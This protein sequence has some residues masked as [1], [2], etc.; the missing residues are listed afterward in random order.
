[1]RPAFYFFVLFSLLSLYSCTKK[2]DITGVS[3]VDDWHRHIDTTADIVILVPDIQIYTYVSSNNRYL[4]TMITSLLKLKSNGYNIKAVLQTG[5]I[6]NRHSTG[7]W[8][9][10]KGIFSKLDNKIPYIMCTGNHDYESSTRNT[11]YSRYFN[12]SSYPYYVTSFKNSAF[13]NSLFSLKINGQP[14]L[15]YSL[16]FAPTD[17]VLTWADSIAAANTDKTGIVLTHAYLYQNKERFNFSAYGYSQLN[18][19]YG[20]SLPDSEQINDGEEIWQKLVYPNDAIRFV[21]CGHMDYPNYAGNLISKNIKGNKCLQ[22]LFDTQ[23]FPEG[24]EGLVQVLAFNK[25]LKTVD[26]FT[27]SLTEGIWMSGGSLH[28]RYVR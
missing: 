9:T 8:E 28:Y 13:E 4:D 21:L 18:S 24:G 2:D 1:M 26:I 23:S 5:D 14:F 19:P 10:A 27:C 7:E 12:Y 17:D 3:I 16:E 6:T 15:I 22:M 20:Y 25:D 11:V